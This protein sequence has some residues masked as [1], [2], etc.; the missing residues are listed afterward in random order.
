MKRILPIC[1]LAAFIMTQVSN[2]K[3]P[4]F[5][6]NKAEIAKENSLQSE[7]NLKKLYGEYIDTKVRN[8]DV[9]SYSLDLDWYEVLKNSD[10][11]WNGTNTIT[12]K[13][14]VVN[15][16]TIELDAGFLQIVSIKSL[17]IDLDFQHDKQKAQLKISLKKSINIGEKVELEIKYK[18]SNVSPQFGFYYF[19]SNELAFTMSEPR[20]ARNW[21]PC[22]DITSDRAL[23][24][25]KIKVPNGYSAV[26]N[27]VRL[28]SLSIADTSY[29]HWKHKF[30][31]P[32]YLMAVVASKFITYSDK[33]IKKDSSELSIDYYF[34]SSFMEYSNNGKTIPA[35]DL[36]TNMMAYYSQI[37]F[38]YPYEKY[39]IVSIAPI[40][41]GME[42][43]TIT[44]VGNSWITDLE[45]SGFAHELA[46]HWIG[47]YITCADWQDLW[48]NEGGATWAA[49][50]WM[51]HYY[52][53][54]VFNNEIKT[55][56]SKYFQGGG[57]TLPP[58]YNLDNMNLFNEALTYKKSGMVY[59]MLSAALGEEQFIKTLQKIFTTYPLTS[60]TTQ[61]FR[62]IVKQENPNYPLSWDTF[63]E[64]W[65]L[66]RGH[67]ELTLDFAPP[68]KVNDNFKV[69]FKINQTQLGSD[70]PNIF[71]MPLF[72]E[73]TK[74][75][76][77]TLTKKYYMS[78]REQS[79]TDTL[80]FQPTHYSINE[81]MF[82]GKVNSIAKVEE[83]QSGNIAIFPSIAQA[84]GEIYCSI[85][86]TEILGNVRYEIYNEL[87]EVMVDGEIVVANPVQNGTF[88]FKL[89]NLSAGLYIARIWCNNNVESYKLI[90]K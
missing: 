86:N 12:L 49:S 26:S 5:L 64:Q 54:D 67:P 36:H 11:K 69:E 7:G 8:Y 76:G 27:G 74:P 31:M 58:I 68:T 43:N 78:Q 13:S 77:D 44:T 82:L 15:L 50:M 62:D 33:Y 2:A 46:H 89:P 84:G 48:I 79:F 29:F 30:P 37:F 90:V 42:N 10:V 70:V 20:N 21:M 34:D 85:K 24:E 16:D 65:L 23:S 39:G 72:I 55:H 3:M 14:K 41:G 75:N 53:K 60:I 38:E 52:G 1:L 17:G 45:F 61:Q 4:K 28:D 18:H 59:Q 9:I 22:N 56:K 57:A 25:I 83:E 6:L 73:Y 35:F 88:S 71:E 32:T 66:Q 40:N 63:F 80:D 47:N 87:G 81:Y 51:G 19:Q